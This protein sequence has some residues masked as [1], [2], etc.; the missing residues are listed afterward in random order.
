MLRSAEA[1][2]HVTGIAVTEATAWKSLARFPP[3]PSLTEIRLF[4]LCCVT[5][6]TD[7]RDRRL[8]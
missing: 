1:D 3:T 2:P 4:A 7:M 5:A 8:E 6:E